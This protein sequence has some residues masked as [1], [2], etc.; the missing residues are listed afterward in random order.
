MSNVVKIETEK[1]REC[2][3]AGAKRVANEIGLGKRGGAE[4]EG[5]NASL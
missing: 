3:D 5:G 4:G 2:G 1:I